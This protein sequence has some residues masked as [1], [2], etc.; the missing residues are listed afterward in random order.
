MPTARPCRHT[1]TT[2]KRTRNTRPNSPPSSELRKCIITRADMKSRINSRFHFLLRHPR[3]SCSLVSRSS[4][5][6]LLP[7]D[8]MGTVGR[9]S[10][11]FPER[12]RSETDCLQK[13]GRVLERRML[14]TRC[15]TRRVICAGNKGEAIIAGSLVEVWPGIA[16]PAACWQNLK[17]FYE[18]EELDAQAR[19]RRSST[20]TR[21]VATSFINRPLPRKRP[22]GCFTT[23]AGSTQ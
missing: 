10:G 18:T 8:P 12:V 13:G 17:L 21:I 15:T 6:T 4:L 1:V 2:W 14:M 22:A 9:S 16:T 19:S 5:V 20:A 3:V 23:S 7:P 11:S